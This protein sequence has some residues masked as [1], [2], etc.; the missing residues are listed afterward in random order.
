MFLKKVLNQPNLVGTVMI[1][2][3]IGSGFVYA[4]A[5]DGFNVETATGSEVEAWLAA[6]GGGGSSGTPGDCDC[7]NARCHVRDHD[8]VAEY[9]EKFVGVKKGCKS[10]KSD[11]SNP[12]GGQ[13]RTWPCKLKEGCRTSN[14]M[15]HPCRDQGCPKLANPGDPPKVVDIC[16]KSPLTSCDG[17]CS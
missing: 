11:G 17:K 13:S 8:F 3:L 9:L 5:F 1:A 6:A 2:L 4:F 16:I 10:K 15:T 7:G 14:S 12:C